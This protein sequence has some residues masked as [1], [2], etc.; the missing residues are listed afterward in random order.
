MTAAEGHPKTEPQMRQVSSEWHPR[1]EQCTDGTA[2]GN[3]L[4]LLCVGK[5]WPAALASSPLS[6]SPPISD[7]DQSHGMLHGSQQG[8]ILPV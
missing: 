3:T 4:P 2:T 6:L 1:T 5:Q 8:M 7:T